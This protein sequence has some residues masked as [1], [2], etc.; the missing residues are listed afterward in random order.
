MRVVQE[1]EAHGHPNV[2]AKHPTTFEIT[3][4]PD[5]TRRGDCVI[6]VRSTKGL[7]DLSAE[8]RRTCSVDDA[9]IVVNLQ[10]G[11]IVETIEGRGNHGLTLSH[12]SEIVGR[13]STYL[14]DRTLMIRAD[15]AACDI[16]RDLIYELKSTS[17]RLKI[18]AIVEC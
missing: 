13:R 11:R 12:L 8:F 10:V 7:P 9:R 17:S 15:R 2:I 14:S 1:F 16:N 6:G 4:N 5:L 18:T 3:R